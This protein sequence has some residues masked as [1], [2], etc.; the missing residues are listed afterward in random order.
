MNDFDSYLRTGVYNLQ[1]CLIYLHLSSLLA[2]SSIQ[3]FLWG[4]GK[5]VGPEKGLIGEGFN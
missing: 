4:L 2:L 1:L 3:Y 5:Y